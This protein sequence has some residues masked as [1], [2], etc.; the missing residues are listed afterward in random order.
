MMWNVALRVSLATAFVRG[1]RKIENG[2][3]CSGCDAVVFGARLVWARLNMESARYFVLIV[4]RFPGFCCLWNVF[5]LR[6]FDSSRRG[7]IPFEPLLQLVSDLRPG[8]LHFP[9]AAALTLVDCFI[10]ALGAAVRHAHLH[11]QKQ[12]LAIFWCAI[13][14]VVASVDGNFHPLLFGYLHGKGKGDSAS[15]STSFR[16]NTSQ[17]NFSMFL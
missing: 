12:H 7:R 9:F 6:F 8:A 4:L 2:N 15:D 16:T 17:M 14:S 10:L 3:L 5:G 1:R 13:L 11:S